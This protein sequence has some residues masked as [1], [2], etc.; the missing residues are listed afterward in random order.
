MKVLLAEDDPISRCMLE[1][2]LAEWG[3]LPLG[4]SGGAEACQKALR[5]RVAPDARR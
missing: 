5:L 1:G 3:Y 2:A 4:T